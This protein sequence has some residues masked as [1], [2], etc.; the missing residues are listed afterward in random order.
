MICEEKRMLISEEMEGKVDDC[1]YEIAT[2]LN[3]VRRTI[4]VGNL[5]SLIIIEDIENT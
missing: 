4:N 1:C 2:S 5:M 3:R